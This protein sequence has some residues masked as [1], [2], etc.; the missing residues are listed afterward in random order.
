MKPSPLCVFVGLE[1]S[2]GH[3]ID[4]H[5]CEPHFT[6]HGWRLE[7]RP[8]SIPWNWS[9]ADLIV[10]RSCY[11]YWLR[12]EEFA[13]F[14]S[15]REQEGSRLVNP[16]PIVRWNQN[17][18]YLLELA[19]LGIAIP[20]SYVLDQN[21]TPGELQN[22][23]ESCPEAQEFV[24]KPLVGSGGFDMRRLPRQQLQTAQFPRDVMIQPF[25]PEI[26]RGEWSAIY[27]NGVP[28]HAVVKTAKP[29]EYRVQDSH[30]GST[31]SF[32]WEDKPTLREHADRVAAALVARGLP[33]PCYARYDF[34]DGET[35]GALLLME[36]ELIEPTLF[37]THDTSAAERFVDALLS[38]SPTEEEFR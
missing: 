25:L 8:W 31:Q 23:L 34:M 6:Q 21:A 28:S 27:F 38:Y 32:R 24:A 13:D 17:K 5:L 37:L 7:T 36:V 4:D 16:T 10:L 35:E 3:V 33:Q 29:G 19:E 20:P 26:T 15:A 1:D 30:G 11:D 2:T 18:R 22:F 9:Q 12:P 14:L